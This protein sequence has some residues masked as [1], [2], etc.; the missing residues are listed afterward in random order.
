MSSNNN[1]DSWSAGRNETVY[2]RVIDKAGNIS[3]EKSTVIKI[4]KTNPSQSFSVASSTSGSNGWYK[5][6]SIK[7]PYQIV[8]VVF[9]VVNIVLQ[10]EAVVHQVQQQH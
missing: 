1:T 2:Y 9:R 8:K 5:A 7:Q 3:E 6:L 10:Q 4:D